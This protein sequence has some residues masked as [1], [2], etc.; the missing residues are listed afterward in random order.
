MEGQY[1][2]RIGS[3]GT[4][5]LGF[6]EIFSCAFS[7][8]SIIVCAGAIIREPSPL[9]IINCG[10]IGPNSETELRSISSPE[11]TNIVAALLAI[12]GTINLT[13]LNRLLKISTKD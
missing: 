10:S 5:S 7:N 11:S 6:L 2:W 1:C 13:D 12:F 8:W 4:R 9:G 3:Q